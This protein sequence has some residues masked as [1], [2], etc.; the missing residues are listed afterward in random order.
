MAVKKKVEVQ[1]E[2]EVQE[3]AVVQPVEQVESAE[4]E[5][6]EAVAA[7]VAVAED[8]KVVPEKKKGLGF[9]GT[10]KEW[11]RKRIVALKRSPQTIVMVAL[12]LSTALLLIWLFPITRTIDQMSK[13]EWTGLL[14]FVST[15]ISILTLALFGSAFPKRKKPNI[16][17]IVLLFV[18]MAAIITCDI[19]YYVKMDYYL[20]H[21]SNYEA[22]DYAKFPYIKKSLGY[23]IAH[24]VLV[25]ISALLLATLPLYKKL[26]NKINTRKEI[27]SN[28]MNEVI[29]V[30]ED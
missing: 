23:A 17:F 28:E 21:H 10:I 20:V 2:Y 1:P 30:E 26:I 5:Q 24:T 7:E 16:V 14:I 9:W 27:A 8:V 12:F 15:L 4:V 29:D 3:E 25:G 22:A 18:F 11:F 6:V 19:L 13:A